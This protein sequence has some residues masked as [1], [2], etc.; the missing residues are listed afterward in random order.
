MLE[1]LLSLLGGG[2]AQTQPPGLLPPQAPAA[3]GVGDRLMAGAQGFLNSSS[4]MGALGNLLGGISSGS[5]TDP[6]G[7]QGNAVRGMLTDLQTRGLIT[8]TQAQ[9]IAANPKAWEELSKTMIN[10]PM[11]I[12]PDGSI[13][14]TR[15]FGQLGIPGGVPVSERIETV[16]PDGS[17]SPASF[18]KPSLLNPRGSITAPTMP[19]QQPAPQPQQANYGGSPAT[20]PN[21]QPAGQPIVR[22]SGPITS[23][24]PQSIQ[25]GEGIGKGFAEDYT[26]IQQRSASATKTLTTLQRMSQLADSAFEG[27]AAPALQYARSMLASV[28]LPSATVKAGEEFSALANKLTL[29][30]QNGSLGAGVSNADVQFIQNINPNLSHTAAGRK[31]IITTMT[32][33]AKRDQEVAREAVNYRR[34]NGSMDG[35]Q[36]YIA[37]WAEQHLLF[38]GRE[39]TASFGDRF[40]AA[41]DGGVQFGDG[42]FRVIG[43]RP[44]ATR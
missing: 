14:Q 9:F 5:R 21:L 10:V 42:S 41:T 35:F 23:A 15:P 1:G 3:P 44:G 27:A 13:I 29:D 18:I 38:K 11:Q 20:N 7:V 34:A 6:A 16:N 19:G 17:K 39:N 28:G 25:E 24:S 37:Q 2:S 26:K 31:E 32:A 12:A 22:P 40:G 8:P 30:A 4:P 36:T 33:L 43:V